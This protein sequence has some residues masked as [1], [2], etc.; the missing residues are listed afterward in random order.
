MPLYSGGITD[1]N[2][3]TKDNL[4]SLPRWT[5]IILGLILCLSFLSSRIYCRRQRDHPP[6][7]SGHLRLTHP[8]TGTCHTPFSRSHPSGNYSSIRSGIPLYLVGANLS[9]ANLISANL[10][11]ANLE[12]VLLEGAWCDHNTIWPEGFEPEAWGA[13]LVDD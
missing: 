1:E 12:S 13:V 7:H 2:T 4:V 11:T 3:R 6:K 5:L 9:G 8:Y 10:R